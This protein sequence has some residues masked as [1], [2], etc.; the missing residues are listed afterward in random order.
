MARSGY[1]Y[2]LTHPSDASLYKIGVTVLAPERRLAQHNRDFSKY[3]GQVVEATGQ[4]WEIK[5]VITVPDVYWAERAFWGTTPFPDIAYRYGVEIEHMDWD[6]VQ[7]GLEAAKVAGL[8]PP[9]PSRKVRDAAWLQ[10]EL[11]GCGITM[12]DRYRGLVTGIAFQCENGHVFKESPGLVVNKRS[13]PC[14]A[15]WN[16]ASG[17]RAGIRES[18]R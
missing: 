18:L 4:K 9:V 2:V 5:T 13:C 14:C 15:D 6:E 12:L 8:R 1:L 16:V 3:A 11:E 17:P 7:K 10:R